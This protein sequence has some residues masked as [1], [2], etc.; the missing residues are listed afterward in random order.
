MSSLLVIYGP[1]SVSPAVGSRLSYIGNKGYDL[2]R[3]VFTV[4][5]G[6]TLELILCTTDD[7]DFCAIDR[8]CLDGHEANAGAFN[9]L[10]LHMTASRI[11]WCLPPPV[12]RATLS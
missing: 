11:A 8:E 1:F 5:F 2:S 12:T 9:A 7:V 6:N 4:R 10:I 3:D